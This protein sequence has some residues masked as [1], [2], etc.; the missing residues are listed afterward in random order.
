MELYPHSPP[1][2][3]MELCLI[4][5]KDILCRRLYTKTY[6]RFSAYLAE[7][8]SA[9]KMFRTEILKRNEACIYI[10][11]IC[12]KKVLQFPREVNKRSVKRTSSNFHI[13]HL[14]LPSRKKKRQ[15]RKSVQTHCIHFLIHDWPWLRELENEIDRCTTEHCWLLNTE[16]RS[17]PSDR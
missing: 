4:E 14:T 1:S 13:Q 17:H 11:Y 2:F 6:M 9:T 5:H 3:F 8:L 15:F 12:L 10:Q 7:N 16:Q